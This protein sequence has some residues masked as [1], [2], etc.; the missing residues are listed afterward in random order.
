MDCF[1][2]RPTDLLT[3]A[4]SELVTIHWLSPQVQT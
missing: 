4:H 2:S 1:L 3:L